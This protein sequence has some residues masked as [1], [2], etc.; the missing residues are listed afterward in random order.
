MFKKIQLAVF[1]ACCNASSYAYVID[2]H[3]TVENK[4][5]VPM[6]ITVDQPNGQTSNLLHIPAH[7]STQVY[8]QNGDNSGLLYQTSTSPFTIKANGK[9]YL[10]GRV[11]YYVGASVWNKYSFLDAISAAD[12]V[13]VDPSYSCKNG[14]YN[15]TFENKIVI[16]GTP[17]DELPV[18]EF[19]SKVSCQGLK[20]SS[21]QDEDRHYTPTCFDG[22][23]STFWKEIIKSCHHNICHDVIRYTN[24]NEKYSVGLA[25][26]NPSKAEIDKRVGNLYCGSW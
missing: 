19:P 6:V 8:M 15:P 21:L 3:F 12:G 14:G 25:D 20:F 1:I 23:S 13:K 2:T 4:T 16:D 9:L 7:E 22:M 24:G 5:D 11:A 26:S 18:K 10:Q 17:H